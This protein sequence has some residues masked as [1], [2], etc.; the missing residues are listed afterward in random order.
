M[1]DGVDPRLVGICRMAIKVMDFKVI[2][3]LRTLEE[4][5]IN[6]ARGKSWTLDSKHL[7]GLAVDLAPWPVNW[8]DTE[9][10]CGD[11]G[12]SPYAGN[13]AAMGR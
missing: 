13:Q 2:D 10:F 8:K 11:E 12:G 7:D 1:L 5:K 4:Q 6:V 9:M 3:G